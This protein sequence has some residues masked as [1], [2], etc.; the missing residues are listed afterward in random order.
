MYDTKGSVLKGKKIEKLDFIKIKSIC[1]T[2]DTAEGMKRQA[3]ELEKMFIRH[4][5]GQGLESRIY[6]EF[7]QLDNKK[8]NDP[9][10]RRDYK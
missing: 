1:S 10:L 6:K 2:K 3:S 9:I 4:L 5:S 8:A 7:L